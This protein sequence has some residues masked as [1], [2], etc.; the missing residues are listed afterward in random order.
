MKLQFTFALLSLLFSTNVFA[1]QSE[2][3]RFFELYESGQKEQA[4]DSIYSTNKWM[5]QKQDDIHNVK[6]QLINLGEIVG[7]YYG[8]VELGASDIKDRL[9]HVTYMALFER[10][11]VRL[12]FV[13]YRPGEDWIIYSFSFDDNIDDE[14][15]EAARKAIAGY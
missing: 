11:P 2:I 3:D 7:R 15:S 5:S 1:Y 14:L 6:T 10:Q 12:E 4:V 13:F 8:K 9:V